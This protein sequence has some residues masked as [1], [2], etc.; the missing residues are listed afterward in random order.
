[1]E[2][3]NVSNLVTLEVERYFTDLLKWVSLAKRGGHDHPLCAVY[4][5]KD[6]II[7][8][9]GFR[10][11][12]ADISRL[13]DAPFPLGCWL[14]KT[15]RKDI[16]VLKPFLEDSQK[17]PNFD[18]VI[19]NAMK[20][21]FKFPGPQPGDAVEPDQTWRFYTS[22][23]P[24][25][26]IDVANI[27]GPITRLDFEVFTLPIFTPIPELDAYE[28][29]V[30]RH[31]LIMPVRLMDLKR[32]GRRIVFG[33]EGTFLAGPDF[34]SVSSAFEDFLVKDKTE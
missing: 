16:V 26:L 28:G 10:L 27:G 18:E 14:V 9:D 31:A 21:A 32:D 25:F 34:V 23:N 17:A 11:H 5:R 3:E 29:K 30:I 22:F 20:P 4:I 15:I 2:D 12:F 6:K 1:M 19:A 13:E 7:A 8:S 24:S 33:T